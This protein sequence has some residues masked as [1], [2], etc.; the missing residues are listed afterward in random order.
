[1][2]TE[3]EDVLA[4]QKSKLGGHLA[5]IFSSEEDFNSF[6]F[7]KVMQENTKVTAESSPS[8]QKNSDRFLQ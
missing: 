3:I 4:L 8:T 1:M 2:V 6:A 5:S 7:F